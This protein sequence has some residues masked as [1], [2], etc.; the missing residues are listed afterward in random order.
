MQ[1]RS[2]RNYNDF[3][4]THVDG[5]RQF[6]RILSN[7]WEITKASGFRKLDK[8]FIDFWWIWRNSSILWLQ[9]ISGATPNHSQF[10]WGWN[11]NRLG[12]HSKIRPGFLSSELKKNSIKMLAT[13]R[14]T[15]ISHEIQHLDACDDDLER[16]LPAAENGVQ[17][18]L[19]QSRAW[20][21]VGSGSI[22]FSILIPYFTLPSGFH[23][24]KKQ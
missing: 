6:K 3:P 22:D 7:T 11:V 9:K 13:Y 10:T 8:L 17:N 21:A 14:W 1:V 20:T 5:S 18:H 16:G 2:C 12:N 4:P 15:S 24:C 23:H 19:D